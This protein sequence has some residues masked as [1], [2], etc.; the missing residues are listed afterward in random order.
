MTEQPKLLETVRH[1]THLR[2]DRSDDSGWDKTGALS[3]EM[4]LLRQ[5]QSHR[6]ATT[7]ADLLQSPRYEA[8]GQFFLKDLY[9]ARDFRQRDED[10]QR[11]YRVMHGVLPPEIARSLERVVELNDLTWY[12]DEA[13]LRALVDD[14]GVTDT[15]TPEQYAE[16]YRICQN[17]AER[18]RQIELIVEIG[19]RLEQLVHRPLVATTLR[20][21]R[22]PAH[23]VGYGE[24]Q[25]FLERGFWAFK[26]MGGAEEFLLV[27]GRR[28]REIL[29]R[30]Y[31]HHPEP[32]AVW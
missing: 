2:R 13:L 11:V 18:M 31:A 17:Y 25:E 27:I 8:A 26:Q 28:E 29:D 7:Y 14:L 19:R 9:S 22:G 16:A 4:R 5:W 21:A 24:L 15:I 30:I 32:F 3:P 10:I 20:L 12:L 1:I 23:V 6:L